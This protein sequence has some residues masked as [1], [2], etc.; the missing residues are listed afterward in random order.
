[1]IK[2]ICIF[3]DKKE[4][5]K[6]ILIAETDKLRLSDCYFAVLLLYPVYTNNGAFFQQK[7]KN[8]IKSNY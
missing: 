2:L 1:M 7:D 4:K 3:V 5:A 6:N 8:N